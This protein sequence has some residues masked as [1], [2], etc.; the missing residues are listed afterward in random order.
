M[1][2]LL[3]WGSLKCVKVMNFLSNVVS[4][5]YVMSKINKPFRWSFYVP[6]PTMFLKSTIV[7]IFSVFTMVGSLLHAQSANT[8]LE[9]PKRGVAA[10]LVDADDYYLHPNG[11]K[12][13]FYRKKDVYA[14][15]QGNARQRSK[16]TS[17]M[18]QIK[19][20]FGDLS[21]IHI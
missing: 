11:K 2:L 10:E 13:N 5:H 21:L 4:H 18:A 20:T 7:S 9:P 6:F 19:A 12:V 16:S 15:K 17:G 1:L 8:L 3:R 14:L